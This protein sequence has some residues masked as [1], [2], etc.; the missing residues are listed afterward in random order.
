MSS[1]SE[2]ADRN[3]GGNS[4][5]WIRTAVQ[6]SLRRLGTDHLDL[7]QVHRPD[8]TTDLDETLGAAVPT[9]SDS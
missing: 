7:Y 5:R 6:E 9:Q 1:G 3:R 2:V 4:R 8:E